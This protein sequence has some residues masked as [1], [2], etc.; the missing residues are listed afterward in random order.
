MP[1]VDLVTVS[2][3]AKQL[4]ISRQAVY[5]AISEGRLSAVTVLGKIGIERGALKAYRPVEVRVSAGQQRAVQR[6]ARKR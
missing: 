1:C 2:E 5:K 4:G 3:A 6:R